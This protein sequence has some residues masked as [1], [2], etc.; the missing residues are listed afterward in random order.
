MKKVLFIMM[1]GLMFGQKECP[2]SDETILLALK[3]AKIDVKS[4][5]NENFILP[6]SR[7]DNY[8]QLYCNKNFELYQATYI[9][10]LYKLY[11]IKNKKNK[12]ILYAL[13][14]SI[15]IIIATIVLLLY[16]PIPCMGECA[17]SMDAYSESIFIT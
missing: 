10:E 3:H 11:E 14:A 8:I 5:R 7:K 6:Q 1:L 4:L 9:G 16:P 13:G 2:N 15:S 12:Y 17:D